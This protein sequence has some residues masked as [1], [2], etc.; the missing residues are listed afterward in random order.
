VKPNLKDLSNTHS[1]N[2][3]GN[4]K[5]VWSSVKITISGMRIEVENLAKNLS[6]KEQEKIK[7]QLNCCSDD[8]EEA[9]LCQS[10]L[11]QLA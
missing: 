3:N 10:L 1:N 5:K 8:L 2:K 7:R 6:I 4:N 9:R 11:E